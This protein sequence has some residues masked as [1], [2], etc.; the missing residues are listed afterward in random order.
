MIIIDIPSVL[1]GLAVV[2]E[3]EE[4]T[5]LLVVVYCVPDPLVTFI[6]HFILLLNELP[7]QHRIL[8]VADFN[9]DQM[10]PENVAIVDPLIQ[11]PEDYWVLYLMLQIPVLFLLYHHP[12]VIILFFFSKYNRSLYLYGI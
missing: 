8:I 7:A 3:K 5:L 10:L 11:N 6:D 4:E 1:E 12:I 2:L 9:L